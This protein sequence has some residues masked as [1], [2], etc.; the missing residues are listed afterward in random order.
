M[1]VESFR[2]TDANDDHDDG[3]DGGEPRHA[4]KGAVDKHELGPQT[5]ARPRVLSF[6]WRDISGNPEGV[7]CALEEGLSFGLEGRV[8][9]E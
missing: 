3:E 5:V 1:L 7:S 4:S 6:I 9:S 8:A 2:V